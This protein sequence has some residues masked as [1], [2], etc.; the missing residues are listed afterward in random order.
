MTR[1]RSRLALLVVVVVALGALPVAAILIAR[2]GGCDRAPP[3]DD[4]GDLE[5]ACKPGDKECYGAN[6]PVAPLPIGAKD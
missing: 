6:E 2:D 3:D 5:P 1:T 4:D